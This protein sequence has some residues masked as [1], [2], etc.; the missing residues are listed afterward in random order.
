MF[1]ALYFLTHW[2]PL[3]GRFVWT[4]RANK[5]WLKFVY[6]CVRVANVLK[7]DGPSFSS[8][9][10]A[11]TWSKKKTY[12]VISG[13]CWFVFWKCL[14]AIVSYFVYFFKRKRLDFQ[15][16]ISSCYSV[17]HTSVNRFMYIKRFPEPDSLESN[18]PN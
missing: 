15:D 16:E 11:A 7:E 5:L 18:V 8:F 9:K 1:S 13:I 12:N 2:L 14:S 6:T 3:I 4:G 17:Q 10:M